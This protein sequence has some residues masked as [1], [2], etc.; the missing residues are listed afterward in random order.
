M[1]S[2][3]FAVLSLVGAFVGL[4]AGAASAQNLAPYYNAS[5]SATYYDTQF[6]VQNYAQS[7]PNGRDNPGAVSLT[8]TN[9]QVDAASVPLDGGTVQ[10]DILAAPPSNPGGYAMDLSAQSSAIYFFTVNGPLGQEV[11][12]FASAKGTISW[13]QG[14][15]SHAGIS[16]ND[17]RNGYSLMQDSITYNDPGNDELKGTSMF[18]DEQELI[19]YGG[20]T[21]EVSLN[22]YTIY[23]SNEYLGAPDGSFPYSE[24]H[25]VVDPIFTI[26]P[27]YA[28]SN[29]FT[30]DA[31]GGPLKSATPS[32]PE[33]ESWAMMLAGFGAIGGAM[34]NRRRT[35]VLLG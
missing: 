35:A 7:T 11:G 9:F 6:G 14:G 30:L 17:I 12:V 34:R 29:L 23:H 18:D 19:L 15:I 27:H 16:L 32:A 20:E 3:R 33:P 5:I 26:D 28:D 22:A 31:D 4:N 21:V 2:S 10:A 8:R 1:V 13:S 24:D 25:A